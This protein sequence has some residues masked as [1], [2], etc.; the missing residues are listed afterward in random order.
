[1]FLRSEQIKLKLLMDASASAIK[2]N[3]L[4][5]I[6][7]PDIDYEEV[8]LPE[9]GPLKFDFEVEVRPVFDLPRLEAIPVTR[10]KHEVT[11]EQIDR[12]IE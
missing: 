12:E 7:E 6:G 11:D 5:T 8:E 4:Q 2:D 10:T 3:K 9:E 1:M